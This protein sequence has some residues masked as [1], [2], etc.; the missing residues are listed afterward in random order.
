[1]RD[2]FPHSL[3][4]GVSRTRITLLTS[5]G[6]PRSRI[7]LLADA[8][9]AEEAAAI[10]E[11][12]GAQLHSMLVAA[13]C[14]GRTTTIVLSDELTRF[15]MVT[16]PKNSGSLAD[17]RAAA[18]M[19]FRDLYAEPV[20]DWKLDADWQAQQAFL[21]CAI[22]RALLNVLQQTAHKNRL[23]LVS[24]APQFILAWNRWR[25]KLQPHA[26]FGVAHAS[27]LT[28][29]AV[30]AQRLCA[31]RAITMPPGAWQDS[32]WLPEQLTREAL[33]LN[34]PAPSHIQLCGSVPGQWV[35]QSFGALTCTRLDTNPAQAE[36]ALLADGFKLATSGMRP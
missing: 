30:D 28:L 4:I 35:S 17:C 36:S 19:R 14:A 18:E 11:R 23:K 5:G 16:P 15:L 32:H 24:L 8:A 26:W 6:F 13:N 33:R 3:R 1:M 9:V 12:M 20:S 7:S 27:M 21:A 34:L 10:P 2:F 29:G 25:K 22:P 31:V